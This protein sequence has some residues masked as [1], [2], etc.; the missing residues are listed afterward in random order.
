[1]FDSLEN[2]E[3][4]KNLM[5][6]APSGVNHGREKTESGGWR[7]LETGETFRYSPAQR[8]DLTSPVQHGTLTA[9]SG[10]GCRCRLCKAAIAA[11]RRERRST[12][13]Q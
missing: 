1:M 10:R 3:D 2:L 4:L 11:Y 6:E 8:G 12:T 7:D 5:E 13:E 9:Y